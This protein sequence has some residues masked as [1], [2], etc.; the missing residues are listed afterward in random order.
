ME[1]TMVK[2]ID[3]DIE[4]IFEDVHSIER[5]DNTKE[6]LYN[7]VPAYIKEPGMADGVMIKL[8]PN[9]SREIVKIDSSFNERV[10][11]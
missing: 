3:L 1:D 11:G 2:K 7:G 5:D 6:L 10:I 8:Y 9:G 4:T